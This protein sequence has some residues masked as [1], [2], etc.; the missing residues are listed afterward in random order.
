MGEYLQEKSRKELKELCS[1]N[2]IRTAGVKHE[3][4]VRL[5]RN[6]LYPSAS[7]SGLRSPKARGA[8]A[9]SLLKENGGPY[10]T[11]AKSAGKGRSVSLRSSPHENNSPPETTS[12][13][14]ANSALSRKPTWTKSNTF[15]SGREDSRTKSSGFDRGTQ[16]NTALHQKSL[17]RFRPVNGLSPLS[18][19]SAE[20]PGQL[21]SIPSM[22]FSVQSLED[23]KDGLMPFTNSNA[24]FEDLMSPCASEGGENRTG[25]E[26]SD[27]GSDGSRKVS[28]VATDAGPDTLSD[29]SDSDEFR[30][31][32]SEPI[33]RFSSL[34]KRLS[35]RTE[36]SKLP[37]SS[38]QSELSFFT[39]GSWENGTS[40]SMDNLLA[41]VKGRGDVADDIFT[42][43]PVGSDFLVGDSD[44][45]E[46][47]FLDAGAADPEMIV[48]GNDHGVEIKEFNAMDSPMARDYVNYNRGSE[49]KA[50]QNRASSSG[51]I[52]ACLMSEQSKNLRDVNLAGCDTTD[53][54]IKSADSKKE[55][56]IGSPEHAAECTESHHID[57]KITPDDSLT[58]QS[59]ITPKQFCTSGFYKE[60]FNAAAEVTDEELKSA[61]IPL[62]IASSPGTPHLEERGAD[63]STQP[64]S[65]SGEDGISIVLDD[66][67]TGGHADSAELIPKISEDNAGIHSE[68]PEGEASAE[69]GPPTF[70]SNDYSVAKKLEFDPVQMTEFAPSPQTGDN[71]DDEDKE[72][73]RMDSPNRSE[74]STLQVPET[75]EGAGDSTSL[76][77]VSN[78]TKPMKNN[79]HESEGGVIPETVPPTFKFVSS[80]MDSGD[81]DSGHEAVKQ[82]MT[83]NGNQ[84]AYNSPV[85]E[86]GAPNVHCKH[87]Y[88]ASH[89]TTDLEKSKQ[90]SAAVKVPDTTVIFRNIESLVPEDQVISNGEML[91]GKLDPLTN[92]TCDADNDYSA[93]TA[94]DIERHVNPDVEP[95][96][97]PQMVESSIAP[98][99]SRSNFSSIKNTADNPTSKPDLL[100]NSSCPADEQEGSGVKLRNGEYANPVGL[101]D[102]YKG[103]LEKENTQ[104]NLK[105]PF[106]F[107]LWCSSVCGSR[108]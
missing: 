93:T 40:R 81:C 67:Y 65:F 39:A 20:A 36:S 19:K 35:L 33:S 5:L 46:L 15:S 89:L 25:V 78:L 73:G 84:E 52:A 86:L 77:E 68:L 69:L 96:S 31:V 41:S 66:M 2:N 95:V 90:T 21:E 99:L 54:S 48:N 42:E 76:S 61:G 16:E 32:S 92:K 59:E 30:S 51:D 72:D 11:P 104:T 56:T 7:H 64:G 14:R 58:S 34:G 82:D 74:E 107:I 53:T 18:R 4:L 60:Y 71:E 91:S 106:S 23:F 70:G 101:G 49:V 28:E 97:Q 57:G 3:D 44:A 83:C 55:S 17:R 75:V 13:R 8:K 94:E 37:L 102:G 45:L 63:T 43:F 29:F 88:V 26:P 105:F 87:D 80:G 47:S 98:S 62:K 79:Q 10:K 100:A 6:K 38:G 27:A 108:S 50:L 12:F 1:Q 103:G 24:E 22:E 9:P 85:E